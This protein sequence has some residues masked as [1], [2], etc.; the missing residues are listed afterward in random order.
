MKSYLEMLPNIS[1]VNSYPGIHPCNGHE[2]EEPQCGEVHLTPIEDDIC[3]VSCNEG[4]HPTTSTGY[5]GVGVSNGHDEGPR[6]HPRQVDEAHPPPPVHQLQ[7]D[8]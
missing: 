8:P 4:V 6:H 7:G 5:V 3:Q 1:V 2:A